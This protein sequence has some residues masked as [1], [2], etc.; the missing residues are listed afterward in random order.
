MFLGQA[1]R[2]RIH[3]DVFRRWFFA[4]LLLIGLYMLGRAVAAMAS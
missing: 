1:I 4:W 2:T 3:P